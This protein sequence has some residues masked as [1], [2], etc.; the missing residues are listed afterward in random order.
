MSNCDDLFADDVVKESNKNPKASHEKDSPVICI[1]EL[2]VKAGSW[3]D[4]WLMFHEIRTYDDIRKVKRYS[5]ESLK[6]TK[7]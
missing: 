7:G 1:G 4:E 6:A 5:L 2:K 3:L